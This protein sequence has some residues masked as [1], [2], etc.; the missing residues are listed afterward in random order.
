MKIH[1]HVYRV[2]SKIEFDIDAETE[3]EAAEKALEMAKNKE[4]IEIPSEKEF[5][6]VWFSSNEEKS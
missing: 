4:G 6:S 1:I 5:I 2:V 3:K